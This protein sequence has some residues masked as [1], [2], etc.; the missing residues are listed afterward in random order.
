MWFYMKYLH[1]VLKKLQSE[2]PLFTPSLYMYPS[3][4]IVE[5]G[6][7]HQNTNPPLNKLCIHTM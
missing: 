1:V 3:I 4:N 2:Q 5:S 7:K 6:V